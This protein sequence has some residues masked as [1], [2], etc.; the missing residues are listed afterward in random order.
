MATTTV[1][2]GWTLA[3]APSLDG[4]VAIVTGAT[5]GLGYE[6]AL[7][8]AR[9]GA[10]TVLAGRNSDKGARALSRIQRDVPAAKLRF[11]L[12]D[13]ASLASVA[14]FAASVTVAQHGVIDILVNNAAVMALPRRERTSGWLRTTDRVNYLAHFALTVR[15]LDALRASS[16]GSRVVSVSSLAH[17]RVTLDL[18]DFQAERWYDPRRVDG[19]SKLAMLVFALELQ[20]AGGTKRLEPAQYGGASRLGQ[21]RY[22]CQRYRRRR[23]QPQGLADRGCVRTCCAIR[24]R[25]CVALLICRNGSAGER[26]S[27]LR[28]DRRG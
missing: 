14:D 9:R 16:G 23:A 7:G 20:R 10:T 1:K 8:L 18:D 26:R 6:T 27:L 15:L 24:A 13:L 25:R 12:L 4:K 2:D 19:Q 28:P 11:E 17:R 21:N 22:H 5:G 3:D